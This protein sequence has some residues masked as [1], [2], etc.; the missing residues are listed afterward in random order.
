[1]AHAHSYIQTN[2][3]HMHKSIYDSP[4]L[5]SK[6]NKKEFSQVDYG[7][8]VM[9]SGGW[10]DSILSTNSSKWKL[11][12]AAI[13][14]FV[15]A[16]KNT[17]SVCLSHQERYC[18]IICFPSQQTWHFPPEKTIVWWDAQ[19]LKT[20]FTISVIFWWNRFN[21]SMIIVK[22]SLHSLSGLQQGHTEFEKW[23]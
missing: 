15:T 2:N 13:G 23:D 20:I 8:I 10:S 1:M 6:I 5:K 21:T 9:I 3:L 7:V 16:N 11:H 22:N 19:R 17:T 14:I 18:S 12:V 4:L